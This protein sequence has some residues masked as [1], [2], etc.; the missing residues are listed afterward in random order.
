VTVDS[1]TFDRAGSIEPSSLRSLDAI[2]IASALV[3]GDELSAI[4]A[5]DQRL[6]EAARALGIPTIAPS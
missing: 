1:A 5:Y 4:V 3:V 6:S 2:H